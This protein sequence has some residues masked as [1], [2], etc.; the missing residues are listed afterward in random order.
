MVQKK[1][2]FVVK[3]SELHT[4]FVSFANALPAELLTVISIR[5]NSNPRQLD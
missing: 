4:R 3:L 5:W 1:N 2:I